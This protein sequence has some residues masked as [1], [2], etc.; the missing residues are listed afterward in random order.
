MYKES[1]D[2]EP[3]DDNKDKHPLYKYLDEGNIVSELGDKNADIY[4]DTISLYDESLASMSGWLKKYERAIKLAKLQPT[5]GD[6][7]IESKSFPFEGASLA[8]MP[9]I[10]EAA[11]EFNSRAAPELVWSDTL[12]T[13]KIYG[14]DKKIVIDNLDDEDKQALDKTN[15]LLVEPA[16]KQT[17]SDRADRVSKYMNYQVNEKIP[18]WRTNQDKA[19]MMLPIVGTYYKKT[20]W[21]HDIKGVCSELVTAD[22]VIFDMDCDNFEACQNK[23]QEITINRNELISYI[24]GEQEW[25]ISEDELEEGKK[26]FNFVEAY[27]YLDIND[28]GVAAPYVAIL[29]KDLSKV[30]CLYPNYDEDG[31]HV[32]KKGELVKVDEIDCF[33]QYIFIPDPEGGPMGLGWGILLGPMFTAINTNVRQLLDSGTLSNTAANSGL[34][35]AGIGTGR[36]NRGDSGPVEVTIGQLNPV[37]LGGINGSLRDNI[38]QF[39]FAGPSPVLMQLM[40]YMINSARS[41]TSSAMSVA[42]NA[43]EAASLYL[44]RLNQALKVPNTIIARVHDCAKKE[45]QKIHLLDYMYHDSEVYNRVLDENVQYVMEDDFNPKDCDIRMSGN[46]AQGSDEERLARAELNL[47]IAERQAAMGQNIINLRQATIDLL[48]AAKTENIEELVPEVSNEPDPQMQ[49]MVAEKQMEAEL[50]NR[51]QVLRENG[52]RLQEQKLALEAAKEMT[53]LG[54]EGDKQEA[55]ITYKYMQ[56]LKLAYD[57]GMN[58]IPTLQEVERTFIDAEG[59]STNELPQSNT[60]PVRPMAERP[61][62]QNVTPMLGM[63]PS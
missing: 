56:S 58:G 18:F 17:K 23:F 3:T 28:D 5:S 25:D 20:Y 2:I 38:V 21:D 60:N 62:N 6:K 43:G 12:V 45:F 16:Q 63:A 52:Q 42:P 24:R 22:K 31:I 55:D 13:T 32:N 9:Y 15:K 11:L 8:M 54:L 40:E 47:Q 29:S 36:G 49:I 53:S 39:P 50:K 26:T 51:D 7:D 27:T 44:A 4:S 10:L 59:G 48:K 34:I 61:S 33:T 41:M 1:E 19:L 46:P 37:N 14:R 57:M 30:V 35:T